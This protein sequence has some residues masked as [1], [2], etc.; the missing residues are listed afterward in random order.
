MYTTY[1]NVT[2]LPTNGIGCQIID[3]PVLRPIP[4][5]RFC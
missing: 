3:E 5:P 4:K 2:L 1:L